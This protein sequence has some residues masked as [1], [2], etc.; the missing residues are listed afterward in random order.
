MSRCTIRVLHLSQDRVPHGQDP[1]FELDLAP[2]EEVID[3]HAG[4]IARDHRST[5]DHYAVVRVLT[6]H[7]ETR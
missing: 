2:N 3:F 5:V 1:T 4:S 7:Q 6:R